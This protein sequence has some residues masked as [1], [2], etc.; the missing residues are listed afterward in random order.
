MNVGKTGFPPPG[1]NP[2]NHAKV[3]AKQHGI[4]LDQAKAELR[5][6]F[7][8]PKPPSIFDNKPSQPPQD[9]NGLDIQG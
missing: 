6:Q 4:T 5:A 8:D 7:G 3:Y 2:D 9:R 1:M